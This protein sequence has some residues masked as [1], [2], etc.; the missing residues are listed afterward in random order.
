MDKVKSVAAGRRLYLLVGILVALCL[1]FLLLPTLFALQQSLH[2]SP[3]NLPPFPIT[4][5]P[6]SKTITEDP[7][8]D[9]QFNSEHTSLSA[10]AINA[11]SNML[12]VAALSIAATSLYQLMAAPIA[13]QFVTIQA[14][15]RQE[16]VAG[17][18]GSEL[19]WTKAD[20]TAFL[21]SIAT[22]SPTLTEGMFSP[23]TY[24]VTRE[25]TATDVQ[26]A[27]NDRF[28][29]SIR[30]RY[31]TTTE[32]I[33]PLSQSLIIASLLERETSDPEEMRIISG[34]IWNRLF[35]GMKLQ[36]D[37][38]LQYAKGTTRNGWWPIVAPRDKYIK[39]AYNTYQ[40]VGLPP[41]P[42]ANPSVAA[43]FAA[44]NPKNTTCLYYFH[45]ND[46]GF[47]CSDTYEAHV[48]MLK[49][50]FGRGK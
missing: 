3:A 27:L 29:S 10:A 16:Q 13:P 28:I 44:L 35:S 11:T 1:T 39:S 15:Y 49:Q 33:V 40:N 19:K 38:T 18:F 46:G 30:A 17:A 34:I 43:V 32:A 23:G 31:A 20:K 36:L 50:V 14:G 42:I 9:A 24:A 4:V 6:K 7:K 25:T 12:E 22:T 5:D 21:K 2:A 47:H 48:K 8:V 41:T 37:A 45:D 26:Q